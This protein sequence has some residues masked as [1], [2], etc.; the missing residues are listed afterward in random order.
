MNFNYMRKK[1]IPTDFSYCGP[2]IYADRKEDIIMI[3]LGSMMIGLS[4]VIFRLGLDLASTIIIQSPILLILFFVRKHRKKERK[5]SEVSKLLETIES[6]MDK[7]EY[8]EANNL[9]NNVF[10]TKLNEGFK[11]PLEKESDKVVKQTLYVRFLELKGNL[12]FNDFIKKYSD[13]SREKLTQIFK[14][15]IDI[16]TDLYLEDSVAYSYAN[17]AMVNMFAYQNTN[18]DKYKL[19]AKIDYNKALEYIDEDIKE[20]FFKSTKIIQI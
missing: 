14:Q 1:R 2:F 5:K 20:D 4:G 16:G 7:G 17:K 10:M 6:Y 12:I 9:L 11:E 13:E 3:C 18:I 15:I 8:N 19:D